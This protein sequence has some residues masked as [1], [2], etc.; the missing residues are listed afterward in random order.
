[1]DNNNNPIL[2]VSQIPA[3]PIILLDF[4]AVEIV[5]LGVSGVLYLYE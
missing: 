5:L 4:I 1:V 2:S 3:A